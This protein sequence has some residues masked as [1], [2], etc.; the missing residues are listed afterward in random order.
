MHSVVP[1]V[2]FLILNW[3]IIKGPLGPYLDTKE[4]EKDKKIL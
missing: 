2:E 1:L 3:L 4:N